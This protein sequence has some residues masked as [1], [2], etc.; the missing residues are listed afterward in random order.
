MR[1][2]ESDYVN[3]EGGEIAF[4]QRNDMSDCRI[5]QK[6]MTAAKMNASAVIIWTD[7]DYGLFTRGI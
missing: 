7:E 5:Y 4:V 1:K 3:F 2:K 6:V